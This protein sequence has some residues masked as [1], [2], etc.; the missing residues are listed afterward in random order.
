[1]KPGTL[2]AENLNLASGSLQSTV[3]VSN[4]QPPYLGQD[5][6]DLLV[7]TTG[8]VVVSQHEELGYLL[9]QASKN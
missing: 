5:L 6:S 1:M 8:K 9:G 3:L 2:V 4:I 7:Q